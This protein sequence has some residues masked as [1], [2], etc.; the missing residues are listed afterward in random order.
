M[1][2]IH[3]KLDGILNWGSQVDF[4]GETIKKAVNKAKK[5]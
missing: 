2:S 4:N 5:L 3:Q 1:S